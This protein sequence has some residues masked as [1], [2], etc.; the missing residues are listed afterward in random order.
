MSQ[1]AATATDNDENSNATD[2]DADSYATKLALGH[3]AAGTPTGSHVAGDHR[4]NLAPRCPKIDE[5]H[6]AGHTTTPAAGDPCRPS[7]P[8]GQHCPPKMSRK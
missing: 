4:Q 3:V 1:C 8:T 6:P 2:N 7:S 5:Q